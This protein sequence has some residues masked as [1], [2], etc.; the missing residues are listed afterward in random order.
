MSFH[1]KNAWACFL[2]LLVVYVPYFAISIVYPSASFPLY[3]GAICA[4]MVVLAV[5]HSAN[6]LITKLIRTSGKTAHLDELDSSIEIKSARFA[7][8]T[9]GFIVTMW[10][11]FAL[12]GL[13]A[14]ISH[15]LPLEAEPMEN[16]SLV[17]IPVLPVI[18]GFQI[19]FAG[20]VIANLVY[21]GG[22]IYG[23]R[24]YS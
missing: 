4:L 8:L 22:I 7:G 2:G 5:F 9:L 23:Y 10:S 17:K 16:L 12:T 11:L 18:A 21:Y 15:A 19:L 14:L 20:F 13:A 24:R 6:A 3:F 1:E